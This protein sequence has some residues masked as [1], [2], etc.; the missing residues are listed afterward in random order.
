MENIF[1]LLTT[2]FQDCESSSGPEICRTEYESECTTS[3]E[4]HDVEDDV[5]EC[6]TEVE[7]KCEEYFPEAEC[8]QK[9]CQNVTRPVATKECSQVMEEV[10]QVVVEQVWEQQCGQVESLE[11]EEECG[12]REAEKC[13]ETSE[14]V[15]EDQDLGLE[16]GEYGAPHVDES[17]D[18]YNAP[19]VH[20][21]AFDLDHF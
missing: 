21:L 6:R 4:V 20:Y 19:K 14:W 5:V 18:T 11:Y 9:S 2:L 16:A 8:Y 10:C 3:Q 1:S 12:E 7:E 17:L 15:C 13:T